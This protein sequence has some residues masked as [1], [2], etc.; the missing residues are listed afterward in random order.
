MSP[1]GEA[2][3]TASLWEKHKIYSHFRLTGEI[4]T[5]FINCNTTLSHPKP[6][7]WTADLSA[8]FAVP[9]TVCDNCH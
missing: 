2:Y 9:Q 3:T 7:C 5:V 4:K 1:S 6:I 8:L